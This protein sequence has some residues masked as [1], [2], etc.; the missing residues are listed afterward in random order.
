MVRT[1]SYVLGHAIDITERVDAERTLR[2]NE[3][4]LR[5]AQAELEARVAERTMALERVNERLRVEIAD[6]EVAERLRARQLID[7]RDT[8]AFL[9]TFSDHLAPVVTFHELVDVVRRVAVPFLA[10]WTMVH[11]VNEDGSVRSV[12][13]TDA[14]TSA[15]RSMRRCGTLAG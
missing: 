13:G 10:D 14:E 15:G 7:Q 8:L 5:S 2:D 6:R 3:H 11:F 12:P 4:A 1:E 9:S